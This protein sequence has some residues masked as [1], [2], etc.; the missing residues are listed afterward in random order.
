MATQ[1]PTTAAGE[2][3]T[4]VGTVAWAN[5]TQTNVAD[6]TTGH[7]ATVVC[8]NAASNYLVVRN[9]GFTI[10]AGAT[11]NGITVE[12]TQFG[13]VAHTPSVKLWNGTSTTTN[14]SIGTAKTYT[15][16]A[17]YTVVT[18]GGTADVWGATLTDTI[19]NSA[20]FGFGISIGIQAGTVIIAIDYVT[21]TVTYTVNNTQY[22]VIMCGM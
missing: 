2:N 18:L 14:S 11:I 8:T 9:F 10:P 12:L 19:V 4:S 21:V 1:G 6:G 20:G 15:Q 16:T 22:S 7:V 17:S 5:P 13:S 3:N